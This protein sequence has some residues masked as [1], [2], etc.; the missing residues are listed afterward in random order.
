MAKRPSVGNSASMTPILQMQ[1]ELHAPPALDSN[2]AE[3]LAGLSIRHYVGPADIVP[4]LDLHQAAFA[5]SR[6][7]LARWEN[8]DFE[9]EFLQ[10]PWWQPERMWLAELPPLQC[11]SESTPGLFQ[12]AKPVAGKPR[13]IGSITWSDRNMA[14]KTVPAV[15]WLMVSPLHRRSGLGLKLLNLL[16]NA[17]WNAGFRQIQLETHTAWAAAVQLY[18]RQGYRVI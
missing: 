12:L 4:W 8:A 17:V 3:E 6:V 1:K 14:G 5:K 9:R 7:G 13:L 11:A 18:E 2:L 15:N 16:E 10:K